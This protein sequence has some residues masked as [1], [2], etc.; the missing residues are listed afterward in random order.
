MDA[1]LATSEDREVTKSPAESP[2]PPDIREKKIIMGIGHFNRLVYR[3]MWRSQHFIQ[4]FKFGRESTIITWI[5]TIP[6]ILQ[7]KVQK[8][9]GGGGAAQAREGDPPI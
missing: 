7:I 6:I 5:C 1:S 8:S 3:V 2:L 9:R 4:D